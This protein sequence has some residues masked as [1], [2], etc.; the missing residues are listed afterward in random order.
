MAHTEQGMQ[1]MKVF[2]AMVEPDASVEKEAKIE[3]RNMF[4][5]LAP[6]N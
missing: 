3:G 4:M 1:V 2:F 6:K 5:I